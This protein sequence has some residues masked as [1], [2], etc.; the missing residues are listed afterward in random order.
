M[1]SEI[2]TKGDKQFRKEK[3]LES[4]LYRSRKEVKRLRQELAV[5]KRRKDSEVVAATNDNNDHQPG[6]VAIDEEDD[7]IFADKETPKILEQ[8]VMGKRHMVFKHPFTCLITGLTSSGKTVFTTWLIENR[9][10]MI[11]PTINEAISC[12]SIDSLQL[13]DLKDKFQGL[14]KLHKGLP[15]TKKPKK[16]KESKPDKNILIVIINLMSETKGNTSSLRGCTI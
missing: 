5:A 15:K 16:L 14:I 9:E 2:E 13:K 8:E 10:E 1:E 12:Y 6:V 11:T 4:K 7:D 3:T